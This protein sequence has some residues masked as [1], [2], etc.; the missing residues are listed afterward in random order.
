[1]GRTSTPSTRCAE[2]GCSNRIGAPSAGT[3]AHR[4]NVLIDQIGIVIAPVA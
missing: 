2:F 1:M 3:T 4:V